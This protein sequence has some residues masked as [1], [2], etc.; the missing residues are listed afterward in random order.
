MRVELRALRSFQEWAVHPDEF[1][2]RV[3]KLA[4]RH[5]HQVSKYSCEVRLILES[6]AESNLDN[7]LVPL[8][9]QRLRSIDALLKNELVRR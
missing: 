2:R 6:D 5:S 3:L 7:R 1:V 8:V 4:G 9:K